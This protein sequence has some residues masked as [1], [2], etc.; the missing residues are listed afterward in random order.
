MTSSDNS[1]APVLVVDL[2]GTLIRSD[3]LYE[4]LWSGMSRDW[5]IPFRAAQSLRN[6]RAA[7][8]AM[9]VGRSQ[10]EVATLPYNDTVLAAVRTWRDAGGKTA[11]VTASDQALA[12]EIG[13]HLDIFDEIHG[14]NG[15]HNLKGANKAAFLCEHFSETGFHYIGDHLADLPIWEK[16]KKAL[17]VNAP[18]RL[19]MAV[20]AINHNAEHL[21]DQP[22]ATKHYLK[23]LRPHQWVKNVLIFLPMMAA[24]ETGMVTFFQSLLAFC[25]FC[26]VASSAY[27]MNDLLDL[28]AD[29]KHS[30]KKNRPFAAGMVPIA[31]GTW[32]MVGL[33]GVGLFCAA[34]LGASFF[35]VLLVYFGL[36]TLYSF[37]LKRKLIVDIC[38]LA[39]LYTMRI[40]AGGAATGIPLTVWLLAF[41]MFL[42][43]SLA[44]VKRQAELVENIAQGKVGA[45]G[46][47]YHVDDL[48][49]IQNMAISSGFV[50]VLVLVL[51]VNS[52]D[53]N[54]LYS[55]P[56]FLWGIALVLLY[57]VARMVMMA[58]RGLMHHDPIVYA[59]KDKNS[60]Y[61]FLI[62]LGL[63]VAASEL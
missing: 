44:T 27:V 55:A 24:H 23:A 35:L 56:Y 30:H 61:S 43:F 60:R 31:N 8:K 36:T 52:P 32:L 39:A 17:T 46:R 18:L 49:V 54:T 16:S 51:Y 1:S 59:V 53:I 41:S 13:A 33:L 34:F 12:N 47:G 21:V 29:R 4:T 37:S 7:L 62:I 25:A 57:W 38:T 50:S 3:M 26:M 15:D 63:L 58:H 20:E 45:A 6:G 40:V 28:S 10:V 9:L 22:P 14:S 2:D 5:T 11:L 42:F 19:R 48:P